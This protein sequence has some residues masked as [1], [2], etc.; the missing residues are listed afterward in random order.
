MLKL[1]IYTILFLAA[2][3]GA[4]PAEKLTLAYDSNN[5]KD[6]LVTIANAINHYAGCSVID[7]DNAYRIRTVVVYEQPIE[8]AIG[9]YWVHN[10]TIQYKWHDRYPAEQIYHT[11]FHE[12]GHA[13]GLRHSKYR[14]D[15]MHGSL[16]SVDVLNVRNAAVNLVDYWR[17]SYPDEDIC[18]AIKA[19]PE[20]DH[21]S[22]DKAEA[23]LTT[24]IDCEMMGRGLNSKRF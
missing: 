8:G 19:K 2:C 23:S 15:I 16:A 4:P 24:S 17:A 13:L 10:D 6:R 14:A 1:N 7:V 9:R 12:I 21:F 22:E 20:L 3:G 5:T 18:T 11:L